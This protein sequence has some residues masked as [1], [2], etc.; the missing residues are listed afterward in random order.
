ECIRTLQ[1]AGFGVWAAVPP[2]RGT[3]DAELPQ[4]PLDRLPFETPMALL[5]GSEAR[6]VSASALSMCNGRFTVPLSGLSESLN[7]SVCV[8]VCVHYGALQRRKTLETGQTSDMRGEE[9]N[10]LLESY[11]DRSLDHHFAANLRS[12]R[13]L[14]RAGVQHRLEEP[15]G[16]G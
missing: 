6:G 10:Q 13:S 2:S 1:A 8:A 9:V 15:R 7:V 16:N 11:A 3:E 4:L 14:H 5:F 12:Q